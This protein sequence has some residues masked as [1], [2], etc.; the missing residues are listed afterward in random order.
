MSHAD[1]DGRGVPDGGSPLGYAWAPAASVQYWSISE[2]LAGQ[3]DSPSDDCHSLAVVGLCL[4]ARS[5]SSFLLSAILSPSR[6]FFLLLSLATDTSRPVCS[7]TPSRLGS[8]AFM[9]PFSLF[10][11]VK[12]VRFFIHDDPEPLLPDTTKPAAR[13]RPL[14]SRRVTRS[15]LAVLVLFAVGL[16]LRN[17]ASL[18]L[19][20]SLESLHEDPLPPLY[21]EYTR[22]ERALPQHNPDLPLPEGRSGKYI[23]ME[24]IVVM[25][26]WGNALQELLLDAHVAY[27]SKRSF[28]FH[29]YTWNND[30]SNYTGYG[31]HLIPSKVPITALLAGPVAGDAFPREDE[32]IPRAVD[33]TYFDEVCPHPTVISSHDVSN[34][35]PG[36]V[37]ADKLA[38]AWVEK[39]DSI[40][41]NCVLI[42]RNTSD[43]LFSF[44]IFGDAKRIQPVWPQLS[45]SPIVTHF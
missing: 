12:N 29:P 42:D 44:W 9:Q 10:N 1:A 17:F 23:A 13:T 28:V 37:P 36:D 41:D 24:N 22:A 30:G 45:A 33:K 31:D 4:A 19:S 35:L 15:L 18:R 20:F 21:E 2:P 27:R 8:L 16:A 40:E 34:Y 5:T 6:F 3:W 26:G 32:Q 7:T 11:P 43:H 25:A 39:L 14:F 38:D